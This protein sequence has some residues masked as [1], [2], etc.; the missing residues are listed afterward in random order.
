MYEARFY[1]PALARFTT[2]DPH[3]ENYLDWTPYNYVG[4]NPIILFD[5]DGMDWYEDKDGNI[6]YNQ[7]IHSESQMHDEDFE[8]TYLGKTYTA[9]N[10]Y[11]SLF[12]DV[13]SLETLEGKL[14]SKM[15][16]ALIKNA[17]FVDE[18]D[19]GEYTWEFPEETPTDFNLGIELR[20]NYLGF[21]Q[22]NVY[23][24]NYEEAEGYYNVYGESCNERN[25]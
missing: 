2:I 24:F 17:E 1:D 23:T 16:E 3:A 8:G 10:T 13:K 15:D 21:S 20:K 19:N 22:D 14:Y 12:G 25:S 18:I 7:E 4:N 5:P 11:Y 9:D 6:Q